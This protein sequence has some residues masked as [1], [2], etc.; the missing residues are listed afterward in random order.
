[1]VGLHYYLNNLDILAHR[2]VWSRIYALY[3]AH[4]Y[5]WSVH[6]YRWRR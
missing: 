6:M 1:M 4:T 2:L 3:F 5:L